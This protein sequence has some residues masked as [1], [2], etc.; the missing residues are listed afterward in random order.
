MTYSAQPS[1]VT[2]PEFLSAV[3]CLLL[4]PKYCTKLQPYNILAVAHTLL[5]LCLF[6]KLLKTL[7]INIVYKVFHITVFITRPVFTFSAKIIVCECLHIPPRSLIK[8]YI[9]A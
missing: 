4:S 7:L 6:R 2:C 9:I 5:E 8:K 1:A 3:P